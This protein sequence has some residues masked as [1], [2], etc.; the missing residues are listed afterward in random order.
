[1]IVLEE[2]SIRYAHSGP[3]QRFLRGLRPLVSVGPLPL[4]VSAGGHASSIPTINPPELLP[5]P[6]KT[7]TDP[8]G[9]PLVFLLHIIDATPVLTCYNGMVLYLSHAAV[10]GGRRGESVR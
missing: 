1:M 5:P 4:P 7:E 10:S 8:K 2:D 6:K 9:Q 3:S